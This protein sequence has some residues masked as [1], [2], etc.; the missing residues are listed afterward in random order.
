MDDMGTYYNTTQPV[1]I[2]TR[3]CINGVNYNGTL[4]F[5]GNSTNVVDG[6]VQTALVDCLTPD[7]LIIVIEEDEEKKKVLRKKKI[8]DIKPGDKV[9]SVNPF[10][11]ELEEDTVIYADGEENKKSSEYDEWIFSDGTVLQTVI[12]HRFYNIDNQKFMYME[13]WQIGEHGY[14]VKGEKVELISHKKI[15]EETKHCTVFT[16]KWNNYFANDMLSGNRRSNEVKLV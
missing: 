6:I 9:L 16:E 12:R 15:K 8:K 2:G 11:G 5:D 14:N 7:T 3:M 10:T 13:N 4:K 1:P